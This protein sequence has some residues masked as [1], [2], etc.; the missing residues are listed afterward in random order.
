[1]SHLTERVYAALELSGPL[2]LTGMA[3]E[4]E[5]PKAALVRAVRSDEQLQRMIGNPHRPPAHWAFQFPGY[6]FW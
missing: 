5:V 4:I 3:E 2:S 6:N 1:M